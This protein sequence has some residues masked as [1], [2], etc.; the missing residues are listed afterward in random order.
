MT[1]CQSSQLKREIDWLL[2]CIFDCFHLLQSYKFYRWIFSLLIW[3][4]LMAKVWKLNGI[5]INVRKSPPIGMM[6]A[7]KVQNL[8]VYTK[9]EKLKKI[10]A[11]R[12][13]RRMGKHEHVNRYQCWHL[14][15]SR[16]FVRLIQIV[17]DYFKQAFGQTIMLYTHND[18]SNIIQLFELR[19]G[20]LNGYS[21][22]LEN[23]QAQRSLACPSFH[24]R[25]SLS[26]TLLSD[27]P[28]AS[29]RSSFI[30][31]KQSTWNI[32]TQINV[33]D[34]ILIRQYV[35]SQFICLSAWLWCCC[36][37]VTL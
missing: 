26:L 16:F 1:L 10:R 19:T 8:R 3:F 22:M 25:V 20:R 37:V 9:C 31:L 5:E 14:R 17:Y 32:S 13:A 34:P 18:A 36:G 35:C 24:T 6:P 27:T 12:G 30:T 21:K 29:M 2:L 23:S 11:T 15:D 4:D 7:F 28:W 33:L